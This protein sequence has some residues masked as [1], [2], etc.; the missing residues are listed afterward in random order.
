[1][2]HKTAEELRAG[3]PLIEQSPH[4]EGLVRLIVR[5]PAPDHR[6][7]I[8]EGELDAEVGLVGDTWVDRAG[9][10]S[11]G[12]D[13]FAQITLMNA[14]YAELIAGGPDGWA[15]AGDQVYVDLDIS[16]ANLPVG[17]RVSLGSAIIRF[18]QEPHTGCAKF[19]ARFGSAA[20]RLA[21]SDRGRELRLR[22]ANAIVVQPG[23]FRNGDTVRKLP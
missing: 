9:L 2:R 19:S 12:P 20:L 18:S 17:S 13:R 6:E 7:V 11:D 21:N 3:L 4:D 22:G 10:G 1:M 8:T 15:K 16:K 14:R 5:R 23:T